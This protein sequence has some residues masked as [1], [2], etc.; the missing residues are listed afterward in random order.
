[1]ERRTVLK[2]ALGTALSAGAGLARMQGALAAGKEIV[3]ITPGLDLPFWRAVSKGV[4]SA[5]KDKGYTFQALDSH[6]IAQ[7]Q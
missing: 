5:A 4:E 2:L 3:Y 6:N 7:N 1:M